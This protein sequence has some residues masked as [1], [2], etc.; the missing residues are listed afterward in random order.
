MEAVFIV[1]SIFLIVGLLTAGIGLVP[2]RIAQPWVARA[3]SATFLL[4]AASR[5][6]GLVLVIDDPDHHRIDPQTGVL[7]ALVAVAVVTAVAGLWREIV[8][9]GHTLP[10]AWR[11]RDE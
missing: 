2:A 3:W 1:S 10:G 6:N 5:V 9:K 8:V 7:A 11:S 4:L